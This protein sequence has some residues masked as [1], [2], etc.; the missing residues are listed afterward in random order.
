VDLVWCPR[1]LVLL[2]LAFVFIV[3]YYAFFS[4]CL[5]L[6]SHTLNEYDDDDG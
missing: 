5:R 4:D 2:A 3:I 6:T 1:I